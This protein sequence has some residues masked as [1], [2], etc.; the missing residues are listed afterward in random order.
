ME[1]DI[2]AIEPLSGRFDISRISADYNVSRAF[3]PKYEDI[4]A[5]LPLQLGMDNFAGTNWPMPRHVPQP[6][7]AVE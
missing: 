1:K 5:G 6:G 3:G 4:Q 2:K 7:K